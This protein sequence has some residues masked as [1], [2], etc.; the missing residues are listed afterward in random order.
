M[1]SHTAR[2][3][4]EDSAFIE[5][6]SEV[7]EPTWYNIMEVMGFSL[8]ELLEDRYVSEAVLYYGDP[9]EEYAD[10]LLQFVQDWA[11]HKK[12]SRKDA[13]KRLCR[14]SNDFSKLLKLAKAV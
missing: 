2:T 13:E 10:D 1:V 3:K 8:D 11:D 12:T 9:I 6:D 5:G 7:F 14:L 4:L